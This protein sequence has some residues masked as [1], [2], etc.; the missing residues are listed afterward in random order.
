MAIDVDAVRSA[1][2]DGLPARARWMLGE[3]PLGF[4]FSVGRGGPRPLSDED[5]Y[6]GL[7]ESW[8]DLLVFGECNY[9]DG[10]GAR[11]WLAIRR[12]D[13]AVCS[14]DVEARDAISVY[15]TSIERF[16]RTFALLDSSLGAGR[17]LPPETEDRV[18]EIDP[19]GYDSSEWCGL[20]DHVRDCEREAGG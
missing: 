6:G 11:P 20:I 12:A 18:R 15:N 5:V 2:V 4:D 3:I 14:L 1:I 16:I 13:G 7:E 19:E 8:A 10:G 9:A 17:P